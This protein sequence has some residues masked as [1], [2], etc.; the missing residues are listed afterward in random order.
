MKGPI[1]MVDT[2]RVVNPDEK[3][4]QTFHGYG[5]VKFSEKIDY[6]L[7]YG[8]LKVKSAKIIRD[9]TD[10]YPSDHYPIDAVMEF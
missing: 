5:T 1:A 2:F 9:K 7:M 10:I 8:D 4:V 3:D 6:I